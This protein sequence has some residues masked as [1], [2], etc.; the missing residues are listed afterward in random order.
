MKGKR[1]FAALTLGIVALMILSACGP[2]SPGVTPEATVPPSPTPEAAVPTSPPPEAAAPVTL[3]IG[4]AGAP[5]S[6]NPGAGYLSEAYII[7]ELA[8]DAMVGIDL[9]NK[10][11]PRL[12]ES[13][14]VSDDDKTWTFHLRQ[15]VKFHDGTP[16]TAEDMAFSINLYKD[17]G[18]FGYLSDYTT[19]FESV[20]ATDDHT[21]VIHL[22]GPVGNIEYLVLYL[23]ALP[24]HIWEPLAADS[25]GVV[26]FENKEMIGTGPFKMADYRTNEF[27]KLVANPDYFMGAPKVDEA[28]FQTYA[29]P[30]AV[31]QALRGGEVDMV[32][33]LPS[34]LVPTLRT[35][36]NITLVIGDER[37]L[38]DIIFNVLDPA[39]CPKD[40][41]GV[42]SG[43]P[44]LRDKQ[45]RLA[46]AHAINKEQLITVALN[47]LGT[48][49]TGLIPPSLGDWYN[50]EIQD[51][52]FDLEKAK[53]IL[54]DAGYKDTN[55]DGIRETPDG[56]PVEFRF[57]IPSDILSG[58]REA[59]MISSWWREIGVEATPQVLEPD[60]VTQR[61]CPAFDYDVLMWGWGSDPDPNLMLS[62]LT[63]EEIPTGLSESGYSNLEYD[64]LYADQLV[65]VDHEQRRTLI[66]RMQEIMHEDLPYIIPFYTQAVQAYR[67]DRFKGW[68]V[69]E[70]GYTHL[71]DP[72]SLRTVEPV[73]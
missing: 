44:A 66:W 16:F 57:L 55:G 56:Q 4:W 46:L 1:L 17:H 32:T 12:A 21:L 67:N 7:Y 48:P 50:S 73:Q 18:A 68:V 54:E 31:V 65:A 33:E 41:G 6:L 69:V 64:K 5:D 34:T 42:C 37:S 22:T 39:N 61:C 20:E 62:I 38:R 10:Y 23:Y 52:P 25:E 27:V 40:E 72:L 8:Y 30:D 15:D 2:A 47:G 14:E 11:Y 58:P 70:G 53:Q 13:W 63:S 71:P 19:S 3:R 49:G 36:S 60:T 29:N 26:T 24:K 45:V 28:V 59:E 9:S 51:Y 35:E 43:H